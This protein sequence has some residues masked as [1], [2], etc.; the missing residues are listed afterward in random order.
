MPCTTNDGLKIHYEVEG[1][2]EPVIST[3]I[4]RL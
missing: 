1:S 4:T 2:G 3:S